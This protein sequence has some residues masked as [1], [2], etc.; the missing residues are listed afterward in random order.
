MEMTRKAQCSKCGQ[1]Y[2]ND[3][4]QMIYRPPEYDS[5][6]CGTCNAEIDNQ[7]RTKTN[8]KYFDKSNL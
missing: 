2:Y 4:G 3:N 8:I 7:I 6:M 1:W 5:S